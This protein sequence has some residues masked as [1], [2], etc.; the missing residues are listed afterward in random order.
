MNIV[1]GTVFCPD[2][3]MRLRD[4]II[5][6]EYITGLAEPGTLGWDDAIDAVGCYVTPGLVDIHIHGA[7]GSDFCDATQ[8]AVTN[9][10]VYLAGRGI[11]AYLGT[12]MSLPENSLVHIMRNASSLFAQPV[13][14]GATLCGVNM[15][16][17]FFNMEKRGAHNAKY[18]MSPDLYLFRRLWEESNKTIRILN[19]APELERCTQLIQDASSVCTVALAHTQADYD[20]ASAAFDEGASHVTHLFNAMPPFSH[21]E[22]GVV[23]AA[24]DKAKYVEVIADGCHLHPSVVR[25]VFKMFGPGRVCLVSDSM[26][27]AGMPDGVYYFGGQPVTV[28]G[29]RA[30]LGENTIAGSVT[31]LAQCMRNT[32]SYGVPLEQALLAVTANPAHA[33]GLGSSVG[34][35]EPGK[36]ADI[37]IWSR[38]LE[39]EHVYIRGLRI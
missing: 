38:N 23:G 6:G 1:N 19:V 26:R 18:L 3:V 13:S 32:V 4:I 35:L 12:T 16:G 28:S 8:A 2:G 24:A 25:S 10:A 7:M 17:P 14:G 33:A 29:G 11:T 21:R 27:A 37:V 36:R 5:E 9:I 30:A 15:E 34:A 20:R 39:L 31:D 22:P